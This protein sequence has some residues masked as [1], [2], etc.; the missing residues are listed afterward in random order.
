MPYRYSIKVQTCVSAPIHIGKPLSQP[1]VILTHSETAASA[2][3]AA[4]A[5][6]VMLEQAASCPPQPGLFQYAD[7]CRVDYQNQRQLTHCVMQ[8]LCG[9][10]VTPPLL[11]RG[12]GRVK[13]TASLERVP[14]YEDAN[15]VWTPLPARFYVTG[16][17]TAPCRLWRV[18]ADGMPPAYAIL[19]GKGK[20]KSPLFVHIALLALKMQGDPAR[21]KAILGL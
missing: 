1:K 3:S 20:G 11:L 8:T 14:R 19:H 21:R 10:P 16:C 18:E 6:Y 7:I 15:G 9:W 17:G 13:W 12:V 4:R 2:L 5:F